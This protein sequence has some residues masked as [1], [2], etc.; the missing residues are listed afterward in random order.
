MQLG[1]KVGVLLGTK[2]VPAFVVKINEATI[3]VTTNGI[4]RIKRKIDQHV[5]E[6]ETIKRT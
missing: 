4:N 5:R 3:I 1:D 6:Y 2:W